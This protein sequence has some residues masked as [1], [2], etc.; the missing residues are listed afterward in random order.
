MQN[1]GLKFLKHPDQVGWSKSS[2]KR[3]LGS[4]ARKAMWNFSSE[5]FKWL[6]WG[7]I[8][9]AIERCQTLSHQLLFM[10]LQSNIWRQ[11]V[12]EGRIYFSSQFKGT[13]HGAEAM[14]GGV[15]GGSR[16]LSLCRQE[17]KRWMLVPNCFLLFKQTRPQSLKNKT[18][19]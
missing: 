13:V 6:M 4:R 11:Q 1:T 10:W 16:S 2:F 3:A 12:Q 5:G 18:Q 17:A 19:S 7:L 15:W 9:K 14:V 8:L